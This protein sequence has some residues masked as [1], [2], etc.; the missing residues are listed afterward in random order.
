MLVTQAQD[1][2]AAKSRKQAFDDGFAK[3]RQE[4]RVFGYEEGFN[5]CWRNRRAIIQ[6]NS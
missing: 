4:G 6:K 5:K 1:L 2:G 3:G